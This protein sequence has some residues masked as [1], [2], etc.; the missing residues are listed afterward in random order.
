MLKIKIPDEEKKDSPFSVFSED[1]FKLIE[2]KSGGVHSAGPEGGVYEYIGDTIPGVIEKGQLVLIKLETKNEAE[3]KEEEQKEEE[4]EEEEEI[5][6]LRL[7]SPRDQ[8]AYEEDEDEQKDYDQDDGQKFVVKKVMAEYVA[9]KML[10]KLLPNDPVA[11]VHLIKMPD[12]KVYL[13]S[14]YLPN[15]Q[16]DLWMVAFKDHYSEKNKNLTN[17]DLIKIMSDEKWHETYNKFAGAIRIFE[18]K[19]RK[20]NKKNL[21][22]EKDT[23]SIKELEKQIKILTKATESILRAFDTTDKNS[24]ESQKAVSE[25]EFYINHLKENKKDGTYAFKKP[26]AAGATFLYPKSDEDSS[27]FYPKLI[28][29]QQKNRRVAN[30][31]IKNNNTLKKELCK[32]ATARMTVGD[33]GLH[34]GNFGLVEING[35]L[36]LASLDFGAA[37]DNFNYKKTVDP[38]T[39]KGHPLGNVRGGIQY[40]N[41]LLEY[42]DIAYSREMAEAWT[43]ATYP[44]DLDKTI[45]EAMDE[46]AN[47]YGTP[48]PDNANLEKFLESL[49][50]TEMPEDFQDKITLAKEKIKETTKSRVLSLHAEGL[51]R[52]F[53]IY[54]K[55]TDQR[56]QMDLLTDIA[57]RYQHLKTLHP[58]GEL[59]KALEEIKIPNYT[60]SSILP[61][62]IQVKFVEKMKEYHAEYDFISTIPK[63]QYPAEILTTHI[64]S[65]NVGQHTQLRASYANAIANLL[66]REGFLSDTELFKLTKEIIL[67]TTKDPTAKDSKAINTLIEKLTAS[68][69]ERA[70]RYGAFAAV[71]LNAYLLPPD[72]PKDAKDENIEITADVDFVKLLTSTESATFEN[73]MGDQFPSWIRLLAKFGKNNLGINILEVLKIYT[74]EN[75]TE[76]EN[77]FKELIQP[78]I[79]TLKSLAGKEQA[80]IQEEEEEKAQE[81]PMTLAKE[82]FNLEKNVTVVKVIGDA[83]NTIA[84]LKTDLTIIKEQTSNLDDLEKLTSLQKNLDAAIKLFPDSEKSF[85]YA[86]LLKAIN[87]INNVEN[88]LHG[89][90]NIFTIDVSGVVGAGKPESLKKEAKRVENIKEE[91]T[92]IK[93]DLVEAKEDVPQAAPAGSLLN[94][95][96]EKAEDCLKNQAEKLSIKI[97]NAPAIPTKSLEK[98]EAKRELPLKIV[99]EKSKSGVLEESKSSVLEDESREVKAPLNVEAAPQKK[100]LL[101][102][103]SFNLPFPPLFGNKKPIEKDPNIIN[104]NFI[105]GETPSNIAGKISSTEYNEGITININFSNTP[106]NWSSDITKTISVIQLLMEK[107]ENLANAIYNNLKNKLENAVYLPH[108]TAEQKVLLAIVLKKIDNEDKEEETYKKNIDTKTEIIKNSYEFYSIDKP[109]EAAEEK[110]DEQHSNFKLF[111]N[112]IKNNVIAKIRENPKEGGDLTFADQARYDT[113]GSITNLNECKFEADGAKKDTST[114]DPYKRIEKQ[115][116]DLLKK[117]YKDKDIYSVTSIKEEKD[118]TVDQKLFGPPIT[119]SGKEQQY[120]DLLLALKI[121]LGFPEA[122]RLKL[123]P[124]TPKDQQEQ[125]FINIGGPITQG[126]AHAIAAYARH[127][128]YL[129]P[130]IGSNSKHDDHII[131][132]YWG[133][134]EPTGNDDNLK[135][136]NKLE[137]ELGISIRPPYDENEEN[138]KS[139]LETKTQE[140]TKPLENLNTEFQKQIADPPVIVPELK[141]S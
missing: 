103:F 39:G 133:M 73:F 121:V 40:K 61:K 42:A 135:Y 80:A 114:G 88:T 129:A 79:S 124:P 24:E 36:H 111:I 125:I 95:F 7:N 6:T 71:N 62:K 77:L 66:T 96:T 53:E 68:C 3:S 110:V 83:Q 113:K 76:A 31:Y 72:P 16:D 5:Q 8:D 97:S 138:I 57:F 119:D 127:C 60:D 64:T 128:G 28:K 78:E 112:K 50:C 46:I 93:S 141:M 69:L 74:P 137:T 105:S 122:F 131:S 52:L 117:L 12:K 116:G 115:N 87:A 118:G 94:Q 15:Y 41:H 91:I 34:T 38:L 108:F 19:L 11:D 67:N 33:F 14:I 10:K 55:K 100:G 70:E 23:I 4:E 107:N 26:D 130:M 51:K 27:V 54:L 89:E 47:K 22:E 90:N 20:L 21:K 109:A 136:K 123:G 139:M 43:E 35:N 86:N 1:N 32:A 101:G 84:K 65:F 102:S 49:Q 18:N 48:P 9:G 58:E 140:L 2:P 99:L 37:F 13:A 134:L 120:Q 30:K 56:E 25:A 126:V 82:Y 63:Q 98:L 132:P 45:D 29:K 44:D 106:S 85:S 59:D 75:S 81:D 92:G 17:K 104:L